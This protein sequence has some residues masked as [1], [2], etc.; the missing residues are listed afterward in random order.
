MYMFNLFVVLIIDI[1]FSHLRLRTRRFLSR[2]FILFHLSI[3]HFVRF[4]Y[5][6]AFYDFP[7]DREIIRVYAPLVYHHEIISTRSCGIAVRIW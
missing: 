2:C 4:S 6:V 1:S 5:F 7:D 3:W